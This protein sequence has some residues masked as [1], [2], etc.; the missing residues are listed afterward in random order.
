VARSIK[1]LIV[2]LALLLAAVA[3]WRYSRSDAGSPGASADLSRGGELVA[4]IRSDPATY[5]RYVPLGASAATEILT[6]LV[7]AKL[8]RVNRAT[9]QLEPWL[10]ETWNQSDDGLTYTLKLRKNVQFSDGTPF[11]AADV[12][13]S[14]RA[15]YDDRVKSAVRGSTQINGQP[16]EVSA[17]DDTTIAIKFPQ[18][19][20]PGL[21]VLENLPILPR[22][23]LQAAFDAGTFAEQWTPS[24]PL[25]DI[26]GLGP[27]MLV[28]HVSG[29]RLVF[30]RN[31]HYFARDQRGEQLPYLDRLTLAIVPDQN[32]EALR[33]EAGETD[34]M[35]NGE[36]RP[37]DFSAFKRAADE[38][39]V[40]LLDVG[41][42]LDPD[43]LS[44]NLRPRKHQDVRWS[45]LGSRELRQAIA[46]GV[47]RQAI[48][49]TV[50]LGEAVPIS[51]T[52][53]PGNKTWYGEGLPA[54]KHDPARAR[55]LLAS[56]R[57]R[58]TDSDGM[59]EDESGKGVRFS[60]MTQ[61]G[62]NRERVVSV[63]QEQLRG[64]GIAVDVVPL[65]QRGLFQRWSAGE[66]DAMY[67]GLQS[68]STD[69]WLNPEYWLSSGAFHFWN[70]GQPSPST[71]WE[72]RVDALM[73]SGAKEP[74]LAKRQQV[75]ADV[76]RVLLEQIPAIY[77]VAPRL[78]LATSSRVL[79]PTPAPQHPQ[80]LWRADTL[81]V[82]Q[83]E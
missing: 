70:P 60:I 30:A 68:S 37:Q 62:H 32:T 31:P 15:A 4:S 3:V 43:F 27:F 47:D 46:W 79:N 1:T 74:D 28:E 64:L 53:T 52:I 2:A 42:G 63:I 29:Q 21:R 34:L 61:G 55:E 40:R 73:Q 71:E 39:R 23:K 33:L 66:Y 48:I 11:T 81:A 24:K 54:F 13:F 83:P 17:P 82:R 57:L 41:V 22:H 10:A 6:Q 9:D 8:I 18:P 26:A 44:F 80:L 16:L 78:T 67:F 25:S 56:L 19:F 35:A 58:D 59:L 77:F 12:L 14:F 49:D 38:G 20:A 45:W 7:H 65:D 75:F 36:I 69:P 72:A 76:Q 5:N 51:G 50:Y